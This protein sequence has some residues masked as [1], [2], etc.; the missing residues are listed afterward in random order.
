MTKK[1]EISKDNPFRVPDNYFDEVKRDIYAKTRDA[2]KKESKKG[3]FT[4]LKPAIMMA[5]AMLTF[6]IISYSILKLLF[7]EYNRT[8]DQ[9]FSELV[10]HFD[11]AELIDEL[12][13]NNDYEEALPAEQAEI[14]DYLMDSDIDYNTLIE[15]LN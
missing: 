6:V 3:I 10:Y 15:Y 13:E 9:N 4:V 5:A 2:G 12:S 1:G 14:I 11:E 7:P 8:E